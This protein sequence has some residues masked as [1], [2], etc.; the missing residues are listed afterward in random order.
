MNEL[1]EFRQQKDD[2]FQHSPHSPLKPDQRQGFAGLRYFP[3]NPDLDLAVEVVRISEKRSVPMPTST[4][5]VQ[6]YDRFG[7]FSFTVEGTLVTLTIYRNQHGF[8]LPFVDSLANQETYAAGRYLEPKEIAGKQFRVDF[9]YAYNP[10]CAYNE[11][12]SC[13]IPPVENHVPAPIRAG[14]MLFES[15]E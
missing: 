9:N 1:E 7:R 4:G 14:E 2:Y 3:Q 8:F 5:A 11:L 13:P 15:H 10:Y 12:W 6:N